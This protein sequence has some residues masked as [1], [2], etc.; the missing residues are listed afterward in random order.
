MKTHKYDS[1]PKYLVQIGWWQPVEGINFAILA[2]DVIAKNKTEGNFLLKF[3]YPQSLGVGLP[4]LCKVIQELP[5]LEGDEL[6]IN[7]L[8]LLY[9]N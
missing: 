3:L 5:Q 7:D 4:Y 1:Y 6:H 9:P 8:E 2:Q